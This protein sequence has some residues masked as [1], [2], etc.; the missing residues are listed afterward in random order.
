MAALMAPEEGEGPPQ[1]DL[2]GEI[3]GDDDDYDG[4]WLDD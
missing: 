1:G 4:L 3:D 2:Y